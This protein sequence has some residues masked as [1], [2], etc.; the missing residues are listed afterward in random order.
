MGK[1]LPITDPL[2]YLKAARGRYIDKSIV[3]TKGECGVQ[4]NCGRA[5]EIL[6]LGMPLR[7]KYKIGRMRAFYPIQ[8]FTMENVACL[9]KEKLY[10][11][12]FYITPHTS[13]TCT[14]RSVFQAR[15]PDE[16]TEC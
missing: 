8:L 1:P 12:V 9:L 2:H 3:I 5:E 11:G 10:P 16:V 15:F 6:Q 13:T 14:W 7:D 4:T